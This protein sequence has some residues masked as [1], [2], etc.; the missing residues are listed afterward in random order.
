MKRLG[1]E[2]GV[3]A[4]YRNLGR[5]FLA[6]IPWALGVGAM[7]WLG[8]WIAFHVWQREERQAARAATYVA[9]PVPQKAKIKITALV[10]DCLRVDRADLDG[11]DLLIYGRAPKGCTNR[12]G[13]DYTEWHWQLLSPDGTIL[14]QGWTNLLDLH[15]GTK[16]ELKMQIESDDRA[17]ELQVWLTRN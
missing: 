13:T 8:T 12:V 16:G 3:D 17:A 15:E 4:G 2:D 5:F 6:L 7:V 14:H 1:D 9:S 10:R 11:T